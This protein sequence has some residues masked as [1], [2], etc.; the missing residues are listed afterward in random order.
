M[1]QFYVDIILL[2]QHFLFYTCSAVAEGDLHRALN[3]KFLG[4]YII[5]TSINSPSVR[6]AGL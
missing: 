5:H 6:I 4:T 2:M 1:V 3:E